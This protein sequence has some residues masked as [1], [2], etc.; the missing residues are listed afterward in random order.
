MC[1]YHS[2]EALSN[3]CTL[4]FGTESTNQPR[5]QDPPHVLISSYRDQGS[6]WSWTAYPHAPKFEPTNEKI[7]GVSCYQYASPQIDPVI[8]NIELTEVSL[9]HWLNETVPLKNGMQPCGGYK[10][11]QINIRRS[12]DIPVRSET[13]L[14]ITKTLG[15]PPVELHIS[16][17]F[18]GGCGMFAQDDGSFGTYQFS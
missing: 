16:S 4:S 6:L 13:F 5:P 8:S 9:E 2:I 10:I 12:S 1:R 18:Q 11:L 7:R 14:A 3:G 15:V 17:T